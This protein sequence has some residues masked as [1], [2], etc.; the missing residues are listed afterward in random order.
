MPIA[1]YVRTN[2]FC[3]I[4]NVRIGILDSHSVQGERVRYEKDKMRKESQEVSI[5]SNLENHCRPAR[6]NPPRVACEDLCRDLERSN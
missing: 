1:R 4:R 3:Y 6:L 5:F 2:L